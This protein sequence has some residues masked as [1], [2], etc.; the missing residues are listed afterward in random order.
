[1]PIA[2][3]SLT[4]P[5]CLPLSDG[6]KRNFAWKEVDPGEYRRGRL[7][8][9][10]RIQLSNCGKAFTAFV[11]VCMEK[12]YAQCEWSPVAGLSKPWTPP[13]KE[14]HQS[15]FLPGVNPSRMVMSPSFK[16]PPGAR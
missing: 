1:M 3:P 6:K 9:R 10:K 2:P 7:E 5:A 14:H 15:A 12:L 11:R 4:V 13:G 16:A 8:S